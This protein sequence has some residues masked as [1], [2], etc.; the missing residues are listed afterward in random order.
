MIVSSTSYRDNRTST[1]QQYTA[2]DSRLVW[3]LPESFSYEDGATIG[4]GLVTA[5]IILYNSF[6]FELSATPTKQTT[7]ASNNNTILIWGGLLLLDFTLP[8]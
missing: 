6:E 7:T 8:S 3:K 4:V 1:F 2:I 5:G